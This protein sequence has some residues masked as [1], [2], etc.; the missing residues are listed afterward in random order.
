M[1]PRNCLVVSCLLLLLITFV[2]NAPASQT[3]VLD[4]LIELTQNKCTYL[5][6]T[7]L[8]QVNTPTFLQKCGSY[9]EALNANLTQWHN[10]EKLHCLLYYDTFEQLCLIENGEFVTKLISPA[11]IKLADNAS[12]ENVCK[13]L[14][15]FYT[16]YNLSKPA[17]IMLN[18]HI[19]ERICIDLNSDDHS[20]KACSYSALMAFAKLQVNNMTKNV[21]KPADTAAIHPVV[22]PKPSN[23]VTDAPKL[24]PNKNI[25]KNTKNSQEVQVAAVN[26]APQ[27]NV[28]QLKVEQKIQSNSDSSIKQTK[29]MNLQTNCLLQLQHQALNQRQLWNP[30]KPSAAP[31]PTENIMDTADKTP[32]GKVTKATQTQVEPQLP[33]VKAPPP[34]VDE[35]EVKQPAESNVV[36]DSKIEPIKPVEKDDDVYGNRV[37]MDDDDP[38]FSVGDEEH[39]P[40]LPKEKPLSTNEDEDFNRS[41]T[42]DDLST[43]DSYFFSYFMMFCILFVMGY[44]GYHNKQKVLALVLEGRRG[45]RQPRRRP[46]S[47]NYHKLDSNLEEAVTSSCDK[48]TSNVI[49]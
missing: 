21:H 8:L 36:V 24:V 39:L 40:P 43:N 28:Q 13:D 47:A 19:C 9:D 29:T 5:Q 45:R 41:V 44:V 4:K 32:P 17:S 20:V 14:R 25:E 30:V 22:V 15:A 46:N 35:P 27:S 3:S 11:A 49:Y 6:N 7:T 34:V 18:N 1:Y 10:I 48:T 31:K 33:E 26:K 2:Q 42:N 16:I 12:V 37:E 38:P 23:T